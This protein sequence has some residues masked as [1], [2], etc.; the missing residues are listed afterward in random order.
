MWLRMKKEQLQR[1][2]RT[3]RPVIPTVDLFILLAVVEFFLAVFLFFYLCFHLSVNIKF[4][5]SS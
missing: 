2:I 4:C 1:C 3:S 5:V